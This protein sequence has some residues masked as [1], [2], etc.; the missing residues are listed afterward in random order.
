MSNLYLFSYNPLSPDANPSSNLSNFKDFFSERFLSEAEVV[1][2]INVGL[3]CS[4]MIDNY[5]AT[6]VAIDVA[7][8]A[9]LAKTP[10]GTDIANNKIISDSNLNTKYDDDVYNQPSNLSVKEKAEYDALKSN[11]DSSKKV[12][13]AALRVFKNSAAEEDKIT[14]DNISK[15]YQDLSLMI[16]NDSTRSI[17]E[18]VGYINDNIL[19][20]YEPPQ[21][22][23]PLLESIVN[24]CPIYGAF[25][26]GC[27]E[28]FLKQQKM[29]QK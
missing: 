9:D 17:E 20:I 2:I 23:F 5:N 18:R 10:F 25:Y 21:L 3:K 24:D 19:A 15:K 11:R 16:A 14:A 12:A 4:D 26:G 7:Y 6:C 28:S 29:Q 22:L 1:S 8:D 27:E 13:N